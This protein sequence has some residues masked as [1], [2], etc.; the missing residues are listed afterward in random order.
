MRHV[1]C[2]NVL[3]L[4]DAG[5][6][7]NSKTGAAIREQAL[8]V[9]ENLSAVLAG[10]EPAAANDRLCLV[11]AHHRAEPDAAAQGPCLTMPAPR[12]KGAVSR[13]SRS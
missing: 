3:T 5:S 8:V 12:R 13:C 7:P 1:R 9:V 4:G 11:P 6:S 10:R 2:K